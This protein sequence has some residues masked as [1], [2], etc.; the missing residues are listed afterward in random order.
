MNLPANSVTSS[1]MVLWLQQSPSDQAV[2]TEFVGRYGHRIQGGCR[3]WELQAANA[4][5]VTPTV[6]LKLLL[7][8]QTFRNNPEQRFLA[9]LKTI[10]H[11][12][13]QDSTRGRRQIA[14]GGT[15]AN[16]DR[17]TT[18]FAPTRWISVRAFSAFLPV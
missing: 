2:W 17:R 7:V 6:L 8:V 4:P 3:Q 1:T 18:A 15:V 5:G 16:D 10:T 11:H 9:W 14:R 12:A 13:W